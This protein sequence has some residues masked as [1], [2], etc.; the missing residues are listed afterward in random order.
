MP[1]GLPAISRLGARARLVSNNMSAM[2]RVLAIFLLVLLPLQSIWAAAAPYCQHE[3]SAASHPGHHPHEHHVTA[4][5]HQTDPT[6]DAVGMDHADCH[7]CHAAS[8]AVV[9]LGVWFA[10]P[11]LA[12]MSLDTRQARLTAPPSSRP[13]RPQWRG[14]A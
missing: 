9:A 8:P 10:C 3:A 4:D 13:E 14:L 11:A 6:G 7:V 1:I 12:D 2:R 5:D